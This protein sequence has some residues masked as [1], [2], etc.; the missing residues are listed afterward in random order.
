MK[1]PRALSRLSALMST[2]ALCIGL[3]TP[4]N[5]QSAFSPAVFVGE[6][7]VTYFEIEQRTLLL[8]L[9]KF[10]GDPRKEA[11][12]QLVDERLQLMAAER[13]GIAP[14]EGG[15]D[16]ALKSFAERLNME[17]AQLIE[18][19]ANEGVEEETLRA[20]LY[21]RISWQGVVQT[22]F[23]SSVAV[24]EDEIN[25]AIASN[26]GAGGVNVLLSEIVIPVTPQTAEQVQSLALQLSQ[27]NNQ[28]DFE[29]AAKTYSQAATREDG[30]RLNW[31]S[32][33][34]LPP[35]LRPVLMALGPGDVTD[36]IPLPNAMAVFMMRGKRETSMP[37]P[38]YS[39]IEYA[40]YMIPGGY[41]EDALKTAAEMKDRVDTCDDLYGEAYGKPENVLV[42]E[43]LAPGKLPRDY[44]LE[45]AKLDE[46]EVS[47]A[48]TRPTSDGGQALV[49]LM[50]CGRTAE[51]KEETVSRE[52]VAQSL[53]GQRLMSFADG[54]LEQLR[55]ETT[56]VQK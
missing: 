1:A 20:F 16:A 15:M 37:A 8:A 49:F 41:S 50:M 34:K 24:T 55:A 7:V 53:R 52:D 27:I 21:A 47:T 40:A 17:P 5:A 12:K 11:R 4:A 9:M 45:L 14:S 25:R 2:L 35:Q 28:G 36:P 10:P 33:T 51:L 6:K 42:R 13:M 30:G 23:G 29:E 44:A 56:I 39:A 43:A 54:Y 26:T 22:R 46:G 32:I 31:I 18:A 19:L 38:N 3:S 48:L